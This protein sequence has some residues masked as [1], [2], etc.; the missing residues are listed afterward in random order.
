MPAPP[1]DRRFRAYNV[2]LLKSGT[3]SITGIFARSYRSRHE[4]LALEVYAVLEAWEKG[5]AT[6]ADVRDFIR[7]RDGLGSLEMDSAGFHHHFIRLLVETFPDAK[8]VFTLRDCYSWLES[9]MRYILNAGVGGGAFLGWGR[10]KLGLPFDLAYRDAD[11]RKA[12]QPVLDRCLPDFV[13]YWEQGN[14]AV[15]DAVP[16]ARLLVV[17][18][19]E[20]TDSRARLADFLALPRESLDWER[21]HELKAVSDW[22]LG[23]NLSREQLG[24]LASVADCPLMQRFFPGYTL[25]SCLARR[26]R[27]GS[28]E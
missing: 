3:T 12:L 20:L 9:L 5:E 21:S 25:E 17:R 1:P 22:S 6:E 2:G 28:A 18:T 8:F 15:L 23:A 11:A 10:K 27:A 16:S 13:R 26:G 7:R 24:G 4:F 19:H 14:Q